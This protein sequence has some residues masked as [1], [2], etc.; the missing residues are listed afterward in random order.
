MELSEERNIGDIVG[1]NRQSQRVEGDTFAVL[2]LLRSMSIIISGCEITEFRLWRAS[3]FHN[4][5]V[6]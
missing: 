2:T 1:D 5:R 6:A 3:R 4:M